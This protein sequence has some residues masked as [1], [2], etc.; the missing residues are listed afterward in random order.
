MFKEVDVA[1]F[2]FAREKG[3]PAVARDGRVSGVISKAR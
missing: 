2:V 3:L 1:G